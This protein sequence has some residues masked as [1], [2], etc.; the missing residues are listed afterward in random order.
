MPANDQDFYNYVQNNFPGKKVLCAY[1][2]GPTGYH[3]YD[4]LNSHQCDCIVVAPQN[5]P[6]PSMERVKNNRIDSE[7]IV[8][9]LKAG[10]LKSIQVPTEAYRH[11]RHLVKLR[12]HYLIKRR[13]AKLQI[14]ALLLFD[15][16]GNCFLPGDPNSR[17]VCSETSEFILFPLCYKTIIFITKALSN[18]F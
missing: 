8:Q 17:F 15:I 7:T 3:L 4:Y 1:E 14:K 11:L 16:T 12:E 9:H 13:N 2:S 18:Y 5:I 6:K 10:N